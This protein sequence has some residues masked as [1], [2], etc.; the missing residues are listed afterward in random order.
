MFNPFFHPLRQALLNYSEEEVPTM[1]I[2]KSF[3]QG[4]IQIPVSQNQADATI[5][6]IN[7]D[8]ILLLFMGIRVPVDGAI[9]LQLSRIQ[10]V[11]ATT[12]RAIRMM[13]DASTRPIVGFTVV[14]FEPTT[15]NS[16]QSGVIQFVGGETDKTALIEYPMKSS[17]FLI[18]Q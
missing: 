12:V 7:L 5:N 4:S 18:T 3:Q 6:P 1:G 11:D 8:S 2:I 15:I 13:N 9:H 16:V 14:E 10:L 17:S